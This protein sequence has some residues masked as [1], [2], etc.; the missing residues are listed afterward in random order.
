MCQQIV[1]LL[2]NITKHSGQPK[3]EILT[4]EEKEKLLSKHG[5][6]D[7]QVCFNSA[8]KLLQSSPSVF[9]VLMDVSVLFSA[10]L[11]A[12]EGQLREILWVKEETGSEDYIQ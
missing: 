9:Y 4:K 1:D 10:S 7:K 12:G 2:V 11:F 3:I 8:Q 6:E 5:L